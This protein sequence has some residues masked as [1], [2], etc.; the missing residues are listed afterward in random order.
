MT[1]IL[2]SF[3]FHLAMYVAAVC[4][5]V[6]LCIFRVLFGTQGEFSKSL[7]ADL[8]SSLSV[9]VPQALGTIFFLLSTLLC[10]WKFQ[11]QLQDLSSRTLTFFF[12]LGYILMQLNLLL[13]GTLK[14]A[15]YVRSRPLCLY[16]I[17]LVQFTKRDFILYWLDMCR[18]ISWFCRGTFW[19]FRWLK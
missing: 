11:P 6:L 8:Y 12:L 2:D 5:W 3:T 14:A 15:P 7:L 10:G 17:S 19:L 18:M 9:S 4:Y 16:L 13:S 1:W